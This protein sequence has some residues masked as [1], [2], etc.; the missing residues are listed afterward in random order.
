VEHIWVREDVCA[1]FWWGKNSLGRPRRRW[2]GNIKISKR[3]LLG[4]GRMDWIGLAQNR[5][6]W[7]AVMYAR[8]EYRKLV[9]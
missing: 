7:W 5:N 9:Y 1:G 8:I 6:K 3:N 2:K 4:E